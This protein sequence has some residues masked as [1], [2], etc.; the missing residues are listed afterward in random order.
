V[1]IQ[2]VLLDLDGTLLDSNDAH[3]QAW[4]T[5]LGECDIVVPFARVRRLIG[6]GGDKLLPHSRELLV[7]LDADGATGLLHA[8]ASSEDVEHSKPDPD[9]VQVA[10]HKAGCRP[11]EALMLG[12][13][14]YDIAAA[15]RAGVSTAG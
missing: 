11:T 3:A 7:Q 9:V 5:A 13:T 6:M 12:D 8:A 15:S 10:L 1:A 2:A 4:V 14:P